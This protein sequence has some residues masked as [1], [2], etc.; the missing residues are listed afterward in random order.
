MENLEVAHGS[1]QEETP[2]TNLAGGSALN[3]YLTIRK[4]LQLRDKQLVG[5][6]LFCT[7]KG[8]LEELLGL[9]SLRA[10]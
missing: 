7:D 3:R 5:A 6:G 8:I 1:D 4:V 10:S 2:S 9:L